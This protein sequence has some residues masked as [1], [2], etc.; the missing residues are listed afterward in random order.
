MKYYRDNGS[1]KA[2]LPYVHWNMQLAL[3][4]CQV[5][6]K[7]FF[8]NLPNRP[9]AW[10]L[11]IIVFPFGGRYRLPDDDLE[12]ELVQAMFSDN[13][14]RDRI[15]MPMYIGKN[16]DDPAFLLE[17][18]FQQ[19]LATAKTRSAIREAVRSGEIAGELSIDQPA[20]AAVKLE[21]CSKSEAKAL[22]SAEQARNQAIQVD[23]FGPEQLRAN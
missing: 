15:T 11:R 18:A 16:T 13:A 2:D 8:E 22:V 9:I 1:Q 5:A 7:E 6:L 14:L 10:L 17:D 19:V 12:H 23:D 3:Y 20:K 4:N 21:L